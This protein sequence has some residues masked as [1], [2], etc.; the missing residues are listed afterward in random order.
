MQ[1]EFIHTMDESRKRAASTVNDKNMSSS[2]G[3]SYEMSVL[4]SVGSFLHES[5]INLT[6]V[7]QI[8]MIYRAF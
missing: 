4:D 3:M 8:F 1:T 2:L 5:K 7:K 6:L